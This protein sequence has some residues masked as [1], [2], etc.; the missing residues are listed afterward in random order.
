MSHGSI[1]SGENVSNYSAF[2]CLKSLNGSI[3]NQ[4]TCST[5]AR[6]RD[7]MDRATVDKMCIFTGL[8]AFHNG[9]WPAACIEKQS[10]WIS[11]GEVSWPPREVYRNLVC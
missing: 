8:A 11:P 4:H 3:S 1:E 5:R 9:K 6:L 2:T 7:V 10:N